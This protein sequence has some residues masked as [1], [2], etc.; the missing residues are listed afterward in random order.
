MEGDNKLDNLEMTVPQPTGNAKAIKIPKSSEAVENLGLFAT[1]DR[2]SDKHM[3][4][5]KGRMKDWTVH[6][7]N[8][9]LP[10]HSVWTSYNHQI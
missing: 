2:C 8:G 5:M 1:P 6:V 7:K 9:A 10:T 3:T 4:Q